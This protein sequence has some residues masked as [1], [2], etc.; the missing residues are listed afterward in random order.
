ME[1]IAFFSGYNFSIF[2]EKKNQLAAL[3]GLIADSTS[4]LCYRAESFV[5]ETYFLNDFSVVNQVF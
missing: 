3:C 1:E 5:P 2:V 4:T